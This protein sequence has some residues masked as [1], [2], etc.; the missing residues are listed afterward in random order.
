MKK[1]LMLICLIFMTG[2]SAKYTIEFNGN[3]IKD[4]LSIYKVDSDSYNYIKNGTFAPVQA[5]K[6]AVTNLEE[7]IKSDGVEYYNADANDGNAYFDYKFKLS[8][9]ERSYFANTCYD[10]FKVF[11]EKDEIV[12]STGK[13]FKCFFPGYDLDTVDVVIKSNHRILYNNADEVNDDEYIW[14]IT[15]DN[16]DDAN[17]QISFSKDYKKE[18]LK[19]DYFQIL[20]YIGIAGAVA[21]LI[22]LFIIIKNKRVNKI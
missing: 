3:E 4:N 9:F 22:S 6:D 11:E 14:H 2:C 10:Y 5:F 17:I 1:F 18:F 13:K 16:K 19:R 20:I 21:L 7:P 15:K 12:F 8:Y